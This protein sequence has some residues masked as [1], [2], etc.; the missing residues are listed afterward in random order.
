VDLKTDNKICN[1]LTIRAYDMSPTF[2]GMIMDRS[3][4]C[5]GFFY[6]KYTVNPTSNLTK[7]STGPYVL[8]RHD[9]MELKII[10]DLSIWF[11]QAFESNS[12]LIY[13]S[14]ILNVTTFE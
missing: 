2:Y 13:T 1:E 11:D 9:P 14:A 7:R 8:D 10:Q 6:P 3:D 4:G 5:F 12:K